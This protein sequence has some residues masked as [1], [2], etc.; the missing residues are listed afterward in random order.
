MRKHFIGKKFLTLLFAGVLSLSAFNAYAFGPGDS[1]SQGTDESTSTSTTEEDPWKGFTNAD[2]SAFTYLEKGISVSRFQNNH[3]TIDWNQVKNAGIDFVIVR[4]AYG[5]TE[6]PYFDENVKGAKAAGIQVGAYL[7]STAKT[8][9]EAKAEA[10]LAVSKISSYSLEYPVAYDVEDRTMLSGGATRDDI[11]TM[12]NTFCDTIRTAGY[13]PVVYANRTW[14]TNYLNASSL[15]SEVWF[16]SYNADKVY[17]PVDGTNTTIWQCGD[18]GIVNGITGYVTTEYSKKAYGGRSVSEKSAGPV[19]KSSSSSSSTTST[20]SGPGQ[21]GE[22]AG[23]SGW[24]TAPSGEWM[25]YVNG[26]AQTGWQQVDGVWYYLNGNG[27]MQTGWQQIDGKWYYMVSSGAMQTGWTNVNEVWYWLGAD[28]A[29]RTGW[30]II[31]GVW[32]Y[33]NPDGSMNKGWLN[34]DGTWYWMNESGA[35]ASGTTVSINGMDYTF[36]EDGVWIG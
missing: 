24:K 23:L 35:M 10:S 22:V 30:K 3:G 36:N 15:N 29:M 17:R 28:G 21:S 1:L 16:A 9:D 2:G 20:K 4:I 14:L 7:C 31:N 5:T 18:K 8:L 33:L 6:D 12:C 13:T 32:Y 19:S 27:I 26:N 25:Y 34:V 11:T